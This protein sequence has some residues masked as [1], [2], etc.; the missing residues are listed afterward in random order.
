MLREV[1]AELRGLKN[2]EK[3][4]VKLTHSFVLTTE[5][6]RS[7]FGL[8]VLVNLRTGEAY[9]PTEVLETYPSW[10]KMQARDAVR[11]MAK[12]K[13]F[14]DKERHFMERFTGRLP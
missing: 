6:K 1:R 9:M 5:H 13:T 4:T 10:G 14:S 12:G 8:P 3:L 2:V 7:V 11:M